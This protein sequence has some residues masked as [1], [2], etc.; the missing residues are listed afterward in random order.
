MKLYNIKYNFRKIN[1]N[2]IYLTV[3]LCFLFIWKDSFINR[4]MV[5]NFFNFSDSNLLAQELVQDNVGIKEPVLSFLMERDV[6]LPHTDQVIN[7]NMVN[8]IDIKTEKALDSDSI[9]GHKIT[10]IS[11]PHDDL[12]ELLSILS[13]K[14]INGILDKDAAN[15]IL[16]ILLGTTSGN[17]YDGFPLLNF[18]RWNDPSIPESAFADDFVVGEYKTKKIRHSGETERNFKK[19]DKGVNPD[20]I[21]DEDDVTIWEV[22]VNMLWYGQQFDSD[23]FFIYVPVINSVTKVPSIDDTLRINYHIYS[24]I[25]EDFAPTQ[26]LFDCNPGLEFPGESSVRLPFKGEDTV[27]VGITKNRVTH[28]TVQH[29]ALR[30]LRGIY[31]WGWKNHPPRVQFLDFLFELTNAHT[32]KNE[33]DPRGQS[34]AVRNRKLDIDSIGNAAPE[35]KIYKIAKAVL[36]ENVSASDLFNMLNNHEIEPIGTFPEWI[37]LMSNQIQLPP[38]VIDI[39]DFEGDSVDNYDYVIAFMNNELYGTGPFGK[40]IRSWDQGEVIH[41]RI[42]NLDNITHYYRN[43]DFGPALNEDITRNAFNG[44]FSFEL[45][46]FKPTYGAPKVAEMQWRTGWGF[47]PHFSVIQQDGVFPRKSDQE[48]LKPFA[49]PKFSVNRMANYFGYQ[50]SRENRNGDFIFN[51]PRYIIQSKEKRS[52]DH[53][54]EYAE[55][56]SPETQN[57][58]LE[59]WKIFKKVNRKD[60]SKGLII[61]QETEGFGM[62]KMCTHINHVGRFCINDLSKFSPL[63]IRNVDTNF[64]DINDKLYFPTFL[65]NPNREGGDIIPP[66]IAWE[67]FLYLS[68]ENGT[69]FIDPEDPQKGYWTD[70]TYAHGRPIYTMENIEVNIEM[71]RASGQLFYQFDDLFHDNSI[72]S[73][74]PFLSQR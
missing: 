25:D 2:I 55:W 30:F 19:P 42:F 7:G 1:I 23:T 70:L 24:L 29:S 50:Y 74:H 43:V 61:G 45:F 68:P 34:M 59:D 28:I 64:D 67:P 31:T 22:D 52:F 21:D 18:N 14:A 65:I 3:F 11:N 6:R 32:K 35:K 73:P 44:I 49:A 5:K 20:L 51:P 72:F 33:L 38:E 9:L 27:W 69:I 36:N 16:K 40:P 12:L 26:V 39:L 37:D 54:Y 57:D 63:N 8:V 62:A 15:N 41:N 71:P 4:V 53:L 66:T 13:D 17:I 56:V 60:I 10:K 47:R 58:A 46:N 48:L